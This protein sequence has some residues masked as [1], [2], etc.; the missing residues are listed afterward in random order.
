M[1][2][3]LSSRSPLAVCRE[4]VILCLN[5][6][7]GCEPALRV[8]PLRRLVSG[9][10]GLR[11]TPLPLFHHR[12]SG[13]RAEVAGAQGEHVWKALFGQASDS[14]QTKSRRIH[15]FDGRRAGLPTGLEFSNVMPSVPSSLTEDTA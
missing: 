10:E 6:G 13:V 14:D 15:A 9:G 8:V 2:Y 4:D 12:Q 5:D 3:P 11:P 1:L 7:V